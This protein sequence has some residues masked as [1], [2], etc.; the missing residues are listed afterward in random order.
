MIG[1]AKAKVLPL[2]VKALATISLKIKKLFSFIK[3]SSSKV[4]L[5]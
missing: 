2:P 3:H 5:K 4:K 1:I